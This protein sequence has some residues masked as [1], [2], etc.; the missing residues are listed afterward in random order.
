MLGLIRMGAY[1]LS[2][3]TIWQFVHDGNGAAVMPFTKHLALD[4]SHGMIFG[5]CAGVSN[6]TGYDVTLIRLLWAA[7]SFY[8]GFGIGLYILAFIIMPQ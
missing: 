4:P 8:R 1:L 2:G 6:Y 3:F 5:V 7:A